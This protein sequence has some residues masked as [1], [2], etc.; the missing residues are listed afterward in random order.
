MGIFLSSSKHD[1]STTRQESLKSR[2][3]SHRGRSDGRR[4]WI[5]I[6]PVRHAP[7]SGNP[8]ELLAEPSKTAL[9]IERLRGIFYGIMSPRKPVL[10]PRLLMETFD[11]L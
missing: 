1:V 10:S 6:L 3:L 9:V 7:V 11:F 8:D 2:P 5:S 4:S